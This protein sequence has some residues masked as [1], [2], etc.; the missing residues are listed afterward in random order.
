MKE[1][2]IT[3]W[4]IKAEEDLKAATY[5]LQVPEPPAGVIAFHCQQAVEKY[6]KAYLTFRDIR[7]PRTHDLA[8]LLE[9]C[10]EK[11]QDF[12]SIDEEKLA[13]L[14]FYAVYVR[15]PDVFYSPSPD[16]IEQSFALAHL[17]RTIVRKK[18]GIPDSP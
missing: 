6:L 3:R 16:E 4:V 8:L 2:I 14:T 7:A 5:L 11:D 12:A 18:L 9:L 1:E 10:L 13:S 15:Y 17:V